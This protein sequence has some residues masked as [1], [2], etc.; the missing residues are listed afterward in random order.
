MNI[1]EEADVLYEVHEFEDEVVGSKK[2]PH[3]H[4]PMEKCASAINNDSSNIS[5][6]KKMREKNISDALW[7][8][9]TH[10]VNQ[11]LARC[12]MGV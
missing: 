12:S 1:R 6:S 9:R 5:A 7:K 11:Y 3:F 4:G 2:G 8:E 10:S